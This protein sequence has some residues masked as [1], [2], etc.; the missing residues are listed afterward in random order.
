MA[1]SAGSGFQ[2]TSRTVLKVREE[3][4]VAGYEILQN[5]GG[6]GERCVGAECRTRGASLGGRVCRGRQVKCAAGVGGDGDRI[7]WERVGC[8]F[9]MQSPEFIKS[10]LAECGGLRHSAEC[11]QEK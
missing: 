6:R 10:G 4:S 3:C 1:A 8:A 2:E 9:G 7:G 5:V 11:R